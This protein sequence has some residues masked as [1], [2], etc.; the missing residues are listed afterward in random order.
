MCVVYDE[1]NV[2]VALTCDMCA[3]VFMFIYVHMRMCGVCNMRDEY[4]VCNVSVVCA[5]W[6]CVNVYICKCMYV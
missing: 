1:Y 4:D 6:F 2:C 3:C 5:L